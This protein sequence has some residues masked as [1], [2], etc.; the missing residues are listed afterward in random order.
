MFTLAYERRH[1]VL[2]SRFT[3][4]F[5]S[6][7]IAELDRAVIEFTA[8]NGPSH[9]LLDFTQVEAVTVP[10]SKLVKRGGQPAISPGLKRV[11]VVP[12]SQDMAREFANQ[13]ALAGSDGPQIVST[14]QEAYRLLGLGEDPKFEVVV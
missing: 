5:S 6:E 13:Q 2:V 10:M 12:G 14:L 1:K 11:F 9:G 8:R 7:D 3:G 4:V